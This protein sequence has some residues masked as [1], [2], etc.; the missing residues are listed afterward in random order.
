MLE[1]L[2]QL[3]WKSIYN[4]SKEERME[5]YQELEKIVSKE[6]IKMK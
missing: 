6:N 1:L 5:I 2:E 4:K 3:D